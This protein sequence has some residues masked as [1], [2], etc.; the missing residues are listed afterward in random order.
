MFAAVSTDCSRATAVHAVAKVAVTPQTATLIVNRQVTLRASL[1][2]PTGRV[3]AG[4]SVYWSS[5]DTMIARV[6]SIGVVTG[7]SPGGV[8]IAASA[9]GTS[10]TATVTVSAVP[11]TSVTIV[12]DTLTV[13]PGANGRLRA[14][15]Y[16]TSGHVVGGLTVTWGSGNAAV[17]TVDTSG[18]VTGVG[19]GSTRIS[20]SIGGRT[21]SAT[22]VVAVPPPV[23]IAGCNGGTLSETAAAPIVVT[24]NIDNQCQATLT[25]TAGSIEI[26]G[27]IDH[28]STAILVA[29]GGIAIDNQIN[30]GSAVQ[31][32]AGRAFTA[33]GDVGGTNGATVSTLTVFD[34]DS[35]AVGGNIHNGAQAELHSH[36]PITIA[37]AVHDSGTTV[38]WWAPS[39]VVTGGID[40][41]AQVVKENWGGFPD[42]Y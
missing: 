30:G 4:P 8:L 11:V 12:P 38:V 42:Q 37:G 31:V 14:T 20:A 36:G 39:L 5:E 29:T 10:G 9:G 24:G 17:A 34:C 33:A 6:S 21:A 18:Q 7:V 35:L 1:V 13:A 40:P 16:D 3:V 28:A 26:Q 15:A 25:S 2:D 22:A 32:M 23:V 27:T 19:A 41:A